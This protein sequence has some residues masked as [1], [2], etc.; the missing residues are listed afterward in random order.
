MVS[1]HT[2][3]KETPVKKKTENKQKK[4][5]SLR[6]CGKRRICSLMLAAGYPD[7]KS[8]E[9]RNKEKK[10]RTRNKTKILSNGGV[11]RLKLLRAHPPTTTSIS[12]CRKLRNECGRRSW[13]LP[14]LL[15]R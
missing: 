6:S 9:M 8:K 7:E 1:S 13:I 4:R 10:N 12:H 11:E 5:I 14:I 15:P 3:N 2:Q